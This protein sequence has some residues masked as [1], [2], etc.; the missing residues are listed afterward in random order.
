MQVTKEAVS[1][2]VRVRG[3]R[4][5]APGAGARFVS[6]GTGVGLTFATSPEPGDR[7]VEVPEIPVFVSSQVVEKLDDAT[8]DVSERDGKVGLVLRPK[9]KAH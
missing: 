3:E 5:A 2:L 6:T 4:G 8:I 9:R 7:V 1:H